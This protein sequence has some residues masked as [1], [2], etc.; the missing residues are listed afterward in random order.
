[1]RDF[2]NE[3]V[4]KQLR[5]MN[6]DL[7]KI[8]IFDRPRKAMINYVNNL[9]FDDVIKL[10]PR[11]KFENVN[12]R[13][14]FIGQSEGV[15]RALVLVD[16]LGN[17]QIHQMRRRGVNPACVIETSP[18]NF[19]AWVS[20]GPEPMQKEHRKIVA[21]VLAKEFGGDSGSTSANHFGRLAGFTNRKPEYLTPSGYP[22]VR[23]REHS[24]SHAQKS[25]EIRAWAL[26]KGMDEE[27]KLVTRRPPAGFGAKA[28]G[29]RVEPGLAFSKY[30]KQW[31][32]YVELSR[33]ELDYSRGDFAVSS[34]MLNEGY[35]KDEIINAMIDNSPNI[36][37]RKSNHVE[38]YATRTVKAAEKALI[39]NRK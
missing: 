32:H 15:D 37:I 29:K 22:F 25:A 28:T 21:V 35:S 24:G 7:Y 31:V 3:I 16:D 39:I 19:Q 9:A 17:R 13:D 11:L 1:M 18:S 20:L 33:K 36:E 8:G 34:R 5:S 38:D 14:V 12:G 10:I 26:A 4:A 27:A 30:Y 2:V 23:L 6:C